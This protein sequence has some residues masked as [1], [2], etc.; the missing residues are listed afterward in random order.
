[1]NVKP[2]PPAVGSPAFTPQFIIHKVGKN[3]Y[4][5]ICPRCGQSSRELLP[6][7]EVAATIRHGDNSLCIN[8]DR[9]AAEPAPYSPAGGPMSTPTKKQ[10]SYLNNGLLFAAVENGLGTIISQSLNELFGNNIR[11]EIDRLRAAEV[12]NQAVDMAFDLAV[13]QT[14]EFVKALT[15]SQ[16]RGG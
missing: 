16:P 11:L 1:M 3:R 9:A 4:R 8:C 7:C 13:Y 2:T 10:K 12:I 5:F 14:E 6:R 15:K